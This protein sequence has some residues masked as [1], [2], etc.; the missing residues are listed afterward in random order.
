MSRLSCPQC[1]GLDQVQSVPSVYESQTSTY[2]GR[3]TGYSS[4]VAYARGVGIVPTFGSTTTYVSGSSSSL[5]ADQ[6]APPPAPR[7]A[8]PR[9]GCAIAAMF[10]LVAGA[11]FLALIVSF[12]TSGQ[13]NSGRDALILLAV[14]ATPFLLT[15]AGLLI[16]RGRFRRRARRDF[17]AYA[18]VHPSLVTAWQAGYLCHRCHTAFLPDGA[19]GL[20]LGTTAVVPVPRFPDLVAFVAGRLRGE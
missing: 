11:G 10:G 13:E 16:G 8:A 15:A 17:E 6:L 14:L 4:G 12:S 1:G 19:L 7:L 18:A 9:N 3:S 2:T 5:L 20:G